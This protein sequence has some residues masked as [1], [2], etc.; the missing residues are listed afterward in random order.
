MLSENEVSNEMNAVIAQVNDEINND[1]WQQGKQDGNKNED[2]LFFESTGY[3]P[4]STIAPVA[5]KKQGIYH[6]VLI[7]ADE[8]ELISIPYE[9]ISG[10]FN[11]LYSTDETL[12]TLT[13]TKTNYI[14]GMNNG[15][16]TFYSPTANDIE[17]SPFKI[18]AYVENEVGK[19]F[20]LLMKFISKS[21]TNKFIYL[22]T[23]DIDENK[24]IRT[25]Q[26]N[27]FHITD[28]ADARAKFKQ[29]LHRWRLNVD[30]VVPYVDKLGYSAT[31]HGFFMPD[32]LYLADCKKYAWF[33]NC[34][35]QYLGKVMPKGSFDAWYENIAKEVVKYPLT[36]FSTIFAFGAP[37][38]QILDLS[39]MFFHFFGKSSRGKTLLL[40][41]A[42]SVHAN[43]VDPN[44]DGINTFIE[45]WNTTNA[46]LEILARLFD[47]GMGA[48]D[49]L[50]MCDDS[51]FKKSIYTI[52]GG[53]SK[54]RATGGGN[55]QTKHAWKFLALSSG[56]QSGFEKLSKNN[57][58]DATL[59]QAIRFADIHVAG[60]I[61][62]DFDGN[63]LDDIEAETLAFKLKEE[64]GLNF[65]HAGRKFI[66]ALLTLKDSKESL[67]AMLEKDMQQMLEKLT[68]D[69]E[70]KP[71]ERRLMRH[72]AMIAV[73]GNYAV[74]FDILPMTEQQVFDAVVHVRNLWLSEMEHFHEQKA[75]KEDYAQM[76][77][78][79]FSKNM[80]KFYSQ[81]EPK[82]KSGC[83]GYYQVLTRGER[84]DIHLLTSES[85]DE[86][87][88]TLKKSDV[89]A[90]LIEKGILIPP[91]PE[92]DS[93]GKVKTRY[94]KNY[95]IPSA[96]SGYAR[97]YTIDA[98][99]LGDDNEG[100]DDDN[101]VLNMRDASEKQM[102]DMMAKMQ[103]MMLASM[104]K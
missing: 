42:T 77:K 10:Y 79:W 17:F 33:D 84:S 37:L 100:V 22:S 101:D 82:P 9:S 86:I 26:D 13:F 47:G 74:M 92:K 39:T 67:K 32:G 18:V 78:T 76:L 55:A 27:G 69:I 21:N 73:A 14:V 103:A 28:D 41:L 1:E 24:H 23:A 61:F 85:F 11:A 34:D 46:G 99:R 89:C 8:E 64:C 97:L 48:F 70:L 98:A 25:L 57:T 90:E 75:K 40:Q 15:T 49:E 60:Q 91:P 2:V 52:C 31:H 7:P 87:F 56:E 35:E 43:G 83:K 59:G 65:G 5:P 80:T 96:I 93:D 36:A 95:R 4:V 3:L 6:K 104:S 58:T 20:G 29:L 44:S 50:H 62:T 72:F 66:Q 81:Y 30:Y 102:A 16:N 88:G 12:T 45:K 94:Q 71:E 19:K 54:T 51:E 38:L 68:V 63:E 53:T